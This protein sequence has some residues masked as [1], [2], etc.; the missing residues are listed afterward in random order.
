M[1]SRDSV[2]LDRET[3]AVP[4]FVRWDRFISE[5]DWK[6]GQH[7]LSVGPTGAGKT[8]LN[9]MLLR[10]A[11]IPAAGARGPFVVVFGI[12]NRDQELYAPFQREGYE[13]VRKFDPHPD[14]DVRFERLIF[15]PLSAK[16]GAQGYQ[17]KERQFREAIHGILREGYWVSYADDI[18]FMSSELHLRDEFKNLWQVGRSEGISVVASSQEP[19]DIPPMAYSASTHLFLFK[20]TDDYRVKRVSEFSGMNRQLVRQLLPRLPD[21]EF[22][23]FNKSTQQLIRSKVS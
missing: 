8:R 7:V 4:P 2:R 16:F 3:E 9:R 1:R 22:I 13:L 11:P 14:D 17:D 5:W 6:T 21:H 18:N 23:Y 15:A 12:K 20:F 19:I 10:R